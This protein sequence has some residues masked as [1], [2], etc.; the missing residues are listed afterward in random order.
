MKKLRA[1]Y[2]LTKPGIIRGNALT[3][4]AGFL[5]ASK[6]DIHLGSLVAMLIGMSLVI[7]SG[8]VF[9][10]YIDRE[11]DAKMERTKKRALVNGDIGV[12][13]AIIYAVILGLLGF[14]VLLRYTNILTASLGFIGF[15][16]YVILYG[17]FKRRSTL[18]T[19]IGSISGA[20]P[21]VAGYTSVTNRLDLGAFL[22]FTI[23]VCW[24]MPHFF[25]I[26]IYRLKDYKTAGLPVLPI[27]KGI[28][29]TKIQ[30]MLYVAGFL[31]ATCALTA[32]GYTGYTYLAVMLLLGAYWLWRSIQG[33]TTS[34]NTRW[35][36]NMF[37]LSLIVITV[38]SLMLSVNSL[39]P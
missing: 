7:A 20:M 4:T 25:A 33:A 14:T 16:D 34:D 6:S 1:Y 35:A 28:E 29:P 30:I 21:I 36:R 23:L 31:A 27:K 5:L 19:I 38:F 32:F 11:I 26:A 10:N 22:L 12:S 15:I 24:Q 37:L 3:A 9:N 8:C 17:Y 2:L 13:S 18:G 39:L